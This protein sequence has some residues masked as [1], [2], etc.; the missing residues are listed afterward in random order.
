M[1][2][3]TETIVSVGTEP[4]LKNTSGPSK[5]ALRHAQ[6]AEPAMGHAEGDTKFYR[7]VHMEVYAYDHILLESYCIYVRYAA[8][9]LGI[10]CSSA[11]KYPQLIHKTTVNKSPFIFSDAKAQYEMRQYQTSVYLWNVT[12][13][14]ANVFLEYIQRNL[15]A[16]L[17]MNVHTETLERLP[18]PIAM[19][20]TLASR[21]TRRMRGKVHPEPEKPDID[22]KLDPFHIGHNREI[23]AFA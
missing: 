14:T 9:C 17:G 3:K 22:L 8:A 16:G 15:S 10:H 4:E 5:A 7:E 13:T 23:G 12:G 19:Q 21:R 18:K 20:Q 2:T 1:E 11:V 6:P